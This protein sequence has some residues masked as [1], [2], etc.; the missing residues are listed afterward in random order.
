MEA[1]EKTRGLILERAGERFFKYGFSRVTTDELA[2]ELGISKKTL[3]KHFPSKE[4]LLRSVIH[5]EMDGIAVRLEQLGSDPQQ[6]FP[7]T[8]KSL[9]NLAAAQLAKVSGPFMRD[10]HRYAPELWREIDRFRQEMLY[11][12]L[13]TLILEGQERGFFRPDIDGRLILLIHVQTIQSVINPET[14]E[15]LPLRPMAIFETLIRILYGGL[16]T[17]EARERFLPAAKE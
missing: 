15:T 12:R 10:L 4:E 1:E 6:D 11:D 14:L 7:E 2:A 9:M 16:L 13:G 8:L 3:Y 17:D 5:R